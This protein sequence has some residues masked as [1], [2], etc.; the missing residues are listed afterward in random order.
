LAGGIA[1]D[2]ADTVILVRQ[3]GGRTITLEIDLPAL[4][5]SSG[6]LTN[7]EVV[8]GDSVFVE[9]Y[10]V[11]YVYGEVQ[12]PGVYRLEK[13]M[14]L[15]QALSVGGGF[16][17]RAA[18]KDVQINRRDKAGKIQT[19]TGDLNDPLLPDDVVY[20]KESLF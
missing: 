10:P 1:V 11:F 12:R 4:F 13:G 18:K 20:V 9:R 15:I 19:R 3:R 5:K 17:L 6:S 14:T 8:G 2:G 7:P 16:T